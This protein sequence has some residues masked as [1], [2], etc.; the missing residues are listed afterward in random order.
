MHVDALMDGWETW[1]ASGR[2]KNGSEYC[3]APIFI[4]PHDLKLWLG[5]S[6][7]LPAR[8][9][10]CGK[11]HEKYAAYYGGV[12]TAGTRRGIRSF[13]GGGG[14]STRSLARRYLPHG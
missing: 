11:A 12:R 13:A 2:V 3:G 7:R 5:L 14:Q 6:P 10:A 1:L 4:S 8:G 9:P